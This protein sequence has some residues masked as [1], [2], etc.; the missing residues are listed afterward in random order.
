MR[1]ILLEGEAWAI[2]MGLEKAKK[3]ETGVAHLLPDAEP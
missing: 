2:E 1:L 3:G